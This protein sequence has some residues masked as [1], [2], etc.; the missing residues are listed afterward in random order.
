MI[1]RNL[2]SEI[3]AALADTP[4]VFLAGARQTGKSTLARSLAGG[5]CPARYITFDDSGLL[6][7]ARRDP[8][9][10]VAGLDGPVVIDEVQR[11]PELLPAIKLAVDRDRQPGRFLLTGSADVLAL[12]RV[13]GY[14][15]GR[16]EAITLW[17]FTQ[18]EL[19]GAR[20]GFIDA[21][22]GEAAPRADG[23]AVSRE[24][25]IAAIMAGGYPEVQ[26]R[27]REERR[28]AWFD[29]Y[30]A[31]LLQREV[32]EL[33]EI[34]GLAVLPR[35]LGLIAAR[36]S[37]VLNFAD[38]ARDAALPQ[39]TFKR[40]FA[41][42]EALL[43][44]RR[45]P[46]WTAT[47]AGRLVKAPKLFLSDTG[48][49]AFLTGASPRRLL[50]DANPLGPL[51]ETFV[52]NELL[53]QAGWSRLRPRLHHYRRHGGREVDVV[54]EDRE[55]R[56][57]GIEVKATASPSASDAGGLMAFAEEVGPRFVRGVILYLG[58]Q[59]IPYGARVHALP[60]AAIWRLGAQPH[61]V[62]A[63]G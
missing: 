57:V 9:G 58:D 35:L 60:L 30:I 49:A 18:G 52:Y 10:F 32:R 41:L 16:M 55:G 51:L 50:E 22:F 37:G 56:C 26:T 40:Y 20:E 63:D 53:R 13:A 15:T 47:P 24:A 42:L 28:A 6:A 12:P 44:V 11:A 45:C 39:S 33:S 23:P 36:S 31:N 1:Q 17:P 54:L 3:V 38:L 5:P 62:S 2:T 48:L 59:V 29:A 43:L 4:V 21:M 34:E 14:L 8:A 27:P 25:C 61:A 19:A 46:A 7:A